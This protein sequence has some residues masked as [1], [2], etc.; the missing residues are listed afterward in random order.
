MEKQF[1]EKSL[2]QQAKK[3]DKEAFMAIYN[4]FYEKVFRFIYY[5]LGSQS[6]AE[7][8]AQETFLKAMDAIK[9]FQ[10]KSSLQTWLMQIAKFTLMD[11]FRQK[12]RYPTTE[13]QDYL[14]STPF[15]YKTDEEIG[16][17]AD[18]IVGRE[19]ILERI[20]DDL[21]EKYRMT[22]EYRFLKNFSLKETAEALN[23]NLTNVK[24]WQ[25]RALKKAATLSEGL[26]Y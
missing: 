22:L 11:F 9:N 24:V 12:Y 14:V 7:D 20:L 25:H 19:K 18:E 21:P 3:G 16:E 15:E 17:R 1:D 8:I 26:S 23:T 6:E 4:H 10:G 5:K 2:V 13:I